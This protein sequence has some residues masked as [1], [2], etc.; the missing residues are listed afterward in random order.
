[1]LDWVSDWNTNKTLIGTDSV[2]T[3]KIFAGIKQPTGILTG[4]AL[5]RFAL[6]VRNYSGNIITEIV[7][8]IYG[9]YDGYKT[10]AINNSGNVEIGRGSQSIKYNA[11]TGVIEF[12][13]AVQLNWTTP[14]SDI[15]SALGGSS[16]PKLTQIS[17][18]GI[19]TGTLNANQITAGS[20]LASQLD[21]ASIKADIVIG[22]GWCKNCADRQFA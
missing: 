6:T 7:D 14:I 11:Q 8:G 2:I 4:V 1:M 9:F 13:S 3:P 19:Y 5:G 15:V 17:S 18:T 10:F 16:Y 22:C 20:I 21:A 12:G